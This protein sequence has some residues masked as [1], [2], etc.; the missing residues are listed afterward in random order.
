MKRLDIRILDPHSLLLYE[1]IAG[2]FEIQLPHAVQIGVGIHADGPKVPDPFLR[3]G[4]GVD[5]VSGGR[6][7][8]EARQADQHER[9]THGARG[10]EL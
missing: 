7:D 9:H 6:A 4:V 5:P 10:N 3:S 2:A 8:D 1:S